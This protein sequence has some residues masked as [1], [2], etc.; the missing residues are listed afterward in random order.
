LRHDHAGLLGTGCERRRRPR[1]A[2][3]VHPVARLLA[4]QYEVLLEALLL[5]DEEVRAEALVVGAVGNREA[6]GER[7]ASL[8]VER[9]LA[10]QRV[11]KIAAR[12][13]ER[14]ERVLVVDEDVHLA[15]LETVVA[16]VTRHGDPIR[17]RLELVAA[18]G[19]A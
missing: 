11:R 16:L 17:N 6:A 8:A 7:A 3:P 14:D 2:G 19:V 10:Q 13:R 12:R 9:Q 15:A 1:S 18:D 5:R 4:D